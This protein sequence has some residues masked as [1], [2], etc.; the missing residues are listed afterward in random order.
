M[1]A[2]D[3]SCPDW[4]VRLK[5]CR[6]P[7]RED[8]PLWPEG[9]RA[10]AIFKKLRLA[11]VPGNPTMA[12]AGDEWI[13]A[14]VRALFGSL[15]PVTRSR[16][17]RELFLLVP[18]KNSKTTYGALIMVTALLV[19]ERP[20][21]PFIMT[22]PV[23]DVAELAFEAARGAIGL[24]PVLEKKFHVRDHLKT[25]IHRE[26]KAALQIM[27]FDPAVLTGQKAAGVLIDEL[28]VV[29][30]M[31]KAASAIRQLRGGM[32]PY[33]EAFMAFIT[34]QSEEAPSGVFRAELTKAR[35]IRD[36]AQRG[37]MLPVLYEFPE[38]MQKDREAWR[39]PKNWRMVTP[40][41]GRS[42]TIERLVEEYDTAVATGEEEL[43]GWASQ[44]LNIEIGL[45]LRSDRW[46]GADFWEG[47]ARDELTFEEVIRRSEVVA[48]GIDGG[49]LDDLLGFAIV[50][51]DRETRE[52][53]SWSRAWAHPILLDRRKSEAQRFLDFQ[54]DGDL[55]IT[56]E[57]GDAEHEIARLVRVAWDAGVLYQVGVDPYGIGSIL[58]AIVAAGVPQKATNPDRD[59]VLG[60]SQGWKLNAA[61]IT[62]ERAL[63]AGT[64][65]HGG[66]P[67]MA[68]C[69]G[70]ARVEP[71]GN[72]KSIT[73]QASGTAKIDPL[74]ALLDAVAIMSLNPGAPKAPDYRLTFV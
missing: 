38:A 41:A 58:D 25:I 43:R 31:A 36:G 4:E 65:V 68:W 73:K 24:D 10:V 49:G 1:S 40:N 12:E 3:L 67:L 30:K 11:D 62:A 61:I 59:V 42:I 16:M 64:L 20:S 28:H 54:R 33:P 39:S 17:I 8:L 35:M 52:W 74:M 7:I 27:T 55:V 56:E 70:N 14:I 60:I 21:A 51:R 44:H 57:M 48:A 53:L 34:T 72:A 2:W 26:T 18:K 71:K 63:A 46:A 45:A 47:Q 37:A 29:A 9:D 13:F 32:L 23:Q 69:V 5:S 22:A 6:P 50:G 66:R 15:D 19:N